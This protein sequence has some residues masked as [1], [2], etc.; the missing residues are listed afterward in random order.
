MTTASAPDKATADAIAALTHRLRN[1]DPEEDVEVFAARFVHDLRGQGWRPTEARPVPT[2]QDQRHNRENAQAGPSPEYLAAKQ[3]I[4]AARQA[5]EEA[6]DD[7][8]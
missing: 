2:W 6:H 8:D 3:Q 5:R 4:L 7:R 1:R